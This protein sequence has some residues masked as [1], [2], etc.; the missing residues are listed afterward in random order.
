MTS[1][2]Q[3]RSEHATQIQRNT[4]HKLIRLFSATLPA[5]ALISCTNDGQLTSREPARDQAYRPAPE[6]FFQQRRESRPNRPE[7]RERPEPRAPREQTS[8]SEPEL[9]SIPRPQPTPAARSTPTPAPRSTPRP[10]PEPSTGTSSSAE[11]PYGVP[12]PGKPGYVTSPFSP[13]AGYVDVT[14]L[15]PG[16][17]AQDPYSGKVFRVP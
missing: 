9:R 10:T 7:R 14:G 1:L 5:V 6:P 11:V 3:E 16:S 15:T 8:A 4:M 12:V 2:P 13:D 17:K